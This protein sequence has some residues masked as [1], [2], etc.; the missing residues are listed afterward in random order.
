MSAMGVSRSA[1]AEPIQQAAKIF[2]LG[3]GAA[4]VLGAVEDFIEDF[5]TARRICL[6]W[7]CAFAAID[8]CAAGRDRTAKR[9]AAGALP[10]LGAASARPHFRTEC[11]SALAQVF[12]CSALGCLRAFEIAAAQGVFGP[13]HGLAGAV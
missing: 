9:V 2:A 4:W 10:L 11:F 12:E 1:L 5:A 13:S 3:L 6:A 8:S 7:G